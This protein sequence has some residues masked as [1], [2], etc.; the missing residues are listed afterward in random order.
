MFRKSIKIIKTIYNWLKDRFI[1]Q[2][3][4]FPFTLAWKGLK[5]VINLFCKFIVDAKKYYFTHFVIIGSTVIYF[6]YGILCIYLMLR[7]ATEEPAL[8]VTPEQS[9][10]EYWT[11]W[12]EIISASVIIAFYAALLIGFLLIP[13]IEKHTLKNNFLLTNKWYEI[14]YKTN[15]TIITLSF[16]YLICV[17]AICNAM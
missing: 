14:Y 11:E 17:I 7:P 15:I 10:I 16:L 8:P 1:V 9:A 12:L 13:V 3:L 6:L 4:V 5:N 2:A